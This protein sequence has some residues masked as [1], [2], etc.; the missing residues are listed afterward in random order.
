MESGR[1][2]EVVCKKL[3]ELWQEVEESVQLLFPGPY[4]IRDDFGAKRKNYEQIV[5][6][7]E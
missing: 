6:T 3:I 5:V 7:E 2:S 4:M 1:V